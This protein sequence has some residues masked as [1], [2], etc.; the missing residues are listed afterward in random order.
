MTQ[1]LIFASISI[2]LY[3]I[4]FIPYIY[5]VFHGRVVPHP[6]SW[7]VVFIFSAINLF[8]ILQVNWITWSLWPILIRTLA[9]LIGLVCWW[10]MIR[11]IQISRFD[12]I[13][14][15]LAV[16]VIIL[17]YI[18]WMREAIIGMVLVDLLIL[19]PTIKK[20]WI[21]PRTED[22]LLWFTSA[23]SQ[24][25]LLM[26][27]SF[28]TFEN[29]IYWIYAIIAN[30]WVGIFIRFRLKYITSKWYYPIEK[31]FHFRS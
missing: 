21:D 30:I 10:I 25:C 2:L 8:V 26:S 20:I 22:A 7:S 1:S 24:W 29:S 9:L 6:F 18:C 3:M 15:F 23:L 12:Y 11:K 28:L 4:G 5:H 31:I 16:G 19:L 17:L 27:I 14:L 13:S